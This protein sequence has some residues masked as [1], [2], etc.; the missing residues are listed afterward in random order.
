MHHQGILVSDLDRAVAFYAEA[1]GGRP[2]TR[3]FVL[4]GAAAAAVMNGDERTAYA[5][6]LV[7]L[8]S[9]AIE[10]FAFRGE[11]PEWAARDRR[12][13]LPHLGVRVEDVDA[14]LAAVERAGGTRQWPVIGRWGRARVI[15]VADPDGNVLEL[16]DAPVEDIAEAAVR[17]FPDARL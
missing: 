17:M 14:A 3:P 10:L 7:A 12:A 8:G 4:E 9:G 15:Y 16:L 2:L 11:A 1:L 13:R 6:C 5:M